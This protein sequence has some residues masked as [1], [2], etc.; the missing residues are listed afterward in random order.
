MLTLRA[1]SLKEHASQVSFPGGMI[2]ASERG[3]Y[4][5]ALD[6]EVFEEVGIRQ[7]SIEWQTGHWDILPSLYGIRVFPYLGFISQKNSPESLV[8]Q[9]GEVAAAAWLDFWQLFEP[10]AWARRELARAPWE[11]RGWEHVTWGLTAAFMALFVKRMSG[12]LP[13]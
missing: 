6:R 9:P 1:D 12:R 8:L 4:R 3:D 5:L 11:W 2:E 10:E 7:G 13:I